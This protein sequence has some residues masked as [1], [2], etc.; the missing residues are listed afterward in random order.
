MHVVVAVWDTCLCG[1]AYFQRL[2]PECGGVEQPAVADE[3][4]GIDMLVSG[5]KVVEHYHEIVKV[6]LC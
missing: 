2:I 1:M 6:R 5:G 3:S 4:A